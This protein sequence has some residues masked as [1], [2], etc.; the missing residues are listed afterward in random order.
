[1]RE[2]EKAAMIRNDCIRALYEY[3]GFARNITSVLNTVPCIDD[4]IS[5]YAESIWR[6]F[7]AFDNDVKTMVKKLNIR[8]NYDGN[9]ND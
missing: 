4:S 3:N 6:S 1:M 5:E 2:I 8:L 9:A 7:V